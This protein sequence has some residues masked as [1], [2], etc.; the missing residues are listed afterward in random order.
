MFTELKFERMNEADIREEI[1]A[2]MLS[3][4]GYRSGTENNVIREQLLRYPR[5][6]LGRKDSRKDPE[7]R[8]KA[9]Y[10]LEIKSRLRWVI[11]AKPPNIQIKSD[12]VQQAWTYANH[13]EI[14]SIYFTI[15]NGRMLVVFRT[16]EGP[17]AQPILTVNYQDFESKFVVLENLLSPDALLRDFPE[18]KLDIGIPIA[19]GLRSIARIA[20]GVVRFETNSLAHPLLN[21]MQTNISQGA[22][23]RDEEGRMVAFVHTQ[24]P[25]RS[26]QRLNERLGLASFEMVSIDGQLSTDKERPTTFVY[27]DRIV[28]PAGERLLDISTWREVVLPANLV[29]NVTASAVGVYRTGVF[30]GTCATEMQYSGVHKVVMSGSFEL[31][32]I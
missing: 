7:L 29:C 8:G 27:E 18:T 22:I 10:I 15:C 20:N 31:Q 26:L 11:E 25:V 24:G 30:E 4:L 5:Q 23:E 14:R 28:F 2:P 16:A 9:D 13:P 17:N 3:R 6:F 32:L 21:E 12:D 1:I 19:K